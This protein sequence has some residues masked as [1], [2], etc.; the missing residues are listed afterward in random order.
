MKLS[1]MLKMEP[2]KNSEI[3]II[4]FSMFNFFIFEI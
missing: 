3:E 1:R 2:I 4:H